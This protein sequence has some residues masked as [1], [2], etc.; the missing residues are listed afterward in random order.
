[1]WTTN[2]ELAKLL[3]N[4][5]DGYK[6]TQSGSQRVNW[7]CPTC[8]EIIEDRSINQINR[9]NISCPN[10]SDGISYP[11]KVMFNVLRQLSI[12][13]K[14][15][16]TF[17]WSINIE[18]D[19]IKLRGNKVYDFYL[20]RN[21]T[22]YLIETHGEQHYA[23]PFSGNRSRS[24]K[25][26]QENDKLKYELAMS[27]GIDNYIVIDC[28][29][30]EFEYIKNNIMNSRLS[31]VFDLSTIN[32][33]KVEIESTKSL[34]K[35]V[36]SL[37]NDNMKISDISKELNLANITIR[38]YLKK[39]N[40]IG[41]CNYNPKE[42]NKNMKKIVQLDSNN[43]ILKVYISIREAGEYF[44]DKRGSAIWQCL[45]GKSKSS[46]GYK[47]MYLEDYE[48]YINNK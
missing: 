39:A 24:V 12:E 26:E 35:V 7:K 6:Y 8:G 17:D 33:D 29:Q 4:P 11:E 38:R 41:L 32:W 19:N 15:Q 13:F 10:C 25:E 43:N 14:Y 46:H 42:F 34:V 22:T 18:H 27:N 31:I 45:N 1:M 5:E 2:P 9:S 36:A 28:R 48:S 23:R 47:W 40:N 44:N 21:D 37:W 3:V 16:K 20:E 30:S